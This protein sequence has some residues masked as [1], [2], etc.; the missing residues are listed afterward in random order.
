MRRTRILA[1]AALCLVLAAPAAAELNINVGIGIPAPVIAIPVGPAMVVIPGTPVY[2]APGLDV[3]IFFYQGYWWTPYQGYWFRSHAYNGP[4]TA[5]HRPPSAF[6]NLPPN[7]HQ[8][9]VREKPIPYGQFKRHWR[10]WQRPRGGQSYGSP[11][12]GSR[13]RG[14]RSYGGPSYSGQPYGGPS[15]G[16]QSQGGPSHGGGKGRGKHN[17]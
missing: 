3:D 9:V 11:Y 12:H 15:H 16:G 1:C 7:Y 2:Y 4:W 5:M 13:T 10:E 8:M 14:G 17:R 6:M